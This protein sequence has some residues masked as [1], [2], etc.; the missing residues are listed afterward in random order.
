MYECN[1][2]AFLVE[3]AGGVASD[4][5]IM[6]Y[7]KIIV[8]NAGTKPILDIEPTSIHQRSPIFLG[9]TDDVNECLKYVAQWFAYK[10][11]VCSRN[12]N[13][14]LI[15]SFA[16]VETNAFFYLNKNGKVFSWIAIVANVEARVVIA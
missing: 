11:R 15:C 6:R 12:F 5:R 1:P 9:S 7:E 2:M 3:Q 10:R 13:L 4:G 8:R 16:S 14:N